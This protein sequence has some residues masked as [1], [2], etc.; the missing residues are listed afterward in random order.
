MIDGDKRTFLNFCFPLSAQMDQRRGILGFRI[1]HTTGE[2]VNGV[3]DIV[4]PK[5]FLKIGRKKEMAFRKDKCLV[6]RK[7]ERYSFFCEK[8]SL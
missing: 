6:S 8:I 1:I 5:C 2:T 3:F 7:E 4:G